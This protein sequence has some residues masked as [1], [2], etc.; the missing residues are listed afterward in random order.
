M[1]RDFVEI[2]QENVTTRDDAFS[3]R[4]RILTAS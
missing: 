1:N 2:L 4:S 3:R